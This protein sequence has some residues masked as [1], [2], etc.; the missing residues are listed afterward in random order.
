VRSST[1]PVDTD[2]GLASKV[3]QEYCDAEPGP[4]H[5]E[6]SAAARVEQWARVIHVTLGNAKLTEADEIDIG[7][8]SLAL[9]DL[10]A[11][12]LRGNG[13]Q[14]AGWVAARKRLGVYDQFPLPPSPP[15][16]LGG[17]GGGG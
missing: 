11:Q 7:D 10:L 3:F 15:E 16:A 6:L 1:D 17:L 13:F 4:W 12:E 2:P 9:V 14:Q 8:V 5:A